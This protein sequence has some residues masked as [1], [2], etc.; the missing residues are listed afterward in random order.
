M[1]Q[2]VSFKDLLTF[3]T[4]LDRL[5]TVT[6]CSWAAAEC[7]LWET[8]KDKA[9]KNYIMYIIDHNCTYIMQCVASRIVD[10]LRHYG[11][12]MSHAVFVLNL[13]TVP[14]CRKTNRI[15]HTICFKMTNCIIP[16][17]LLTRCGVVRLVRYG[18]PKDTA[19][20][21]LET[22]LLLDLIC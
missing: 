20:A 6:T 5:V 21:E 19:Q 1:Q 13:S 3:R 17:R 16:R 22:C 18:R 2:Y 14:S 7:R 9:F 10:C 8:C 4:H 12:H 11:G 15:K